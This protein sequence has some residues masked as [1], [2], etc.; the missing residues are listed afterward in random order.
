MKLLDGLKLTNELRD[1]VYKNACEH[2]FHDKKWSINHFKMFIASE[3]F[4][5]IKADQK[6]KFVSQ[7]SIDVYKDGALLVNNDLAYEYIF[8][9]YF[10]DELADIVIRC[11]DLAGL[12]KIDVERISEYCYRIA[13]KKPREYKSEIF[14]GMQQSKYEKENRIEPGCCIADTFYSECEILFSESE[15]EAIISHLIMTVSAIVT[16]SN[17]DLNFFIKEKMKYNK[18]RP[19]LHGN[20]Y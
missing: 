9:N 11:L 5:V 19:V 12:L 7:L 18:T 2:G 3:I 20:K 1:E 14:K 6:G 4:E 15:I 10:E 8:S 13:T 16:L 17:I